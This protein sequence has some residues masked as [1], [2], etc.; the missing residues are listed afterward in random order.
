M[1]HPAFFKYLPMLLGVT[2]IAAGQVGAKLTSTLTI[3]EFRRLGPGAA[4]CVNTPLNTAGGEMEIEKTGEE[5]AQRIR[6]VGFVSGTL[7]TLSHCDALVFTEITARSRNTVELDF[8]V[9]LSDEQAPRLCSS[10]RGKSGNG[11][12]WRSAALRAFADEAAQILRAQ[13]KGMPIYSGAL[14]SRELASKPPS[15]QSEAA[16]SSKRL[17]IGQ[18]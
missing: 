7:G 4:V 5:L 16:S 3:P 2:T 12:P 8:R 15:A 14:E 9:V 11:E 18:R 6:A 1:G 17:T 10:A 13:K